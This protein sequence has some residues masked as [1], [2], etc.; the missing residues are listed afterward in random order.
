MTGSYYTEGKKTALRSITMDD[1]TEEYVAWLNDKE[2]VENLQTVSGVY[3]MQML[4]DFLERTISQEGVCMFMILDKDSQ[5]S[6]GTLK[7]HNI[8][9]TH[10]TCNLGMIIGNK[11]YWGGGY[12]TDAL[13]TGLSFAF[14]QLGLRKVCEA[15]NVSNTVSLAMCR[16]VGFREEGILREQVLS[17]GKYEDKIMLAIFARDFRPE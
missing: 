15:A 9:R 16:R 7:I 5:Q 3:T 10:G 11:K 14:N 6:I 12:G 4:K 8:S 1:A 13:R 17:K 2:V